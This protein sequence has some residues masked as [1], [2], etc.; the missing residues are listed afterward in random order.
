MADKKTIRLSYAL[1]LVAMLLGCRSYRSAYCKHCWMKE[2][3]G[4][5]GHVLVTIAP[6]PDEM[7]DSAV[8]DAING[9]VDNDDDDKEI[10]RD[11]RR[12]DDERPL[13]YHDN[14]A[15]LRWHRQEQ[16]M[17]NLELDDDF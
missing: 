8:K 7:F 13:R 15:D 6:E 17:E 9:D 3:L 14:A 12:H 1:P 5:A 11:T 2:K 4:K 16:A 10:R